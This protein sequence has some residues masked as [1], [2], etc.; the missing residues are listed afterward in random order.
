[1]LTHFVTTIT[2]WTER[3]DAL[4]ITQLEAKHIYIEHNTHQ[5]V[6]DNV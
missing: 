3:I 1:M 5:L 2:N 4:C 6:E